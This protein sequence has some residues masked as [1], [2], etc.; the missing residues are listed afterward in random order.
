[1]TSWLDEITIEQLENDPYPIFARLRREAPIAWI[2]VL[3]S[4][5]ASNWEYCWQIAS[6]SQN[7]TG[8]TD[9]ALE[10]VFG[11]PCILSVDGEVHDDLRAMIDP[12]LRPRAV[13]RYIDGL[14]RPIARKYLAEIMDRGSAALMAEYFEP[15]SVRAVGDMLGLKQV[16]S[17]TL[18][19]WF[20]DLSS[21][22]VN[23]AVD[24]QGNFLN[25][26]GFTA[27]DAAHAEIKA[28][29]N[30]LLDRLEKEP[31]DSALSH[32]LHDGMP[33]GQVRPREHIYPTLL[34]ILLGGMQ[35][36]GHAAGATLLG[37]FTQ[38]DQLRRVIDDKR[39]IQKAVQEGLRW[40]SPITTTMGRRP[41]QNFELGGVTLP[42]GQNVL[43]SYGSANRDEAQFEQ[44]EIY[45]LDRPPQPHLAFGTGIHV[46]AGVAFG[47][48]VAQI[49]L[50]ELLGALSSIEL[51]AD[52]E[53]VVWGWFFRGPRELHVR[54]ST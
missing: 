18:R 33:E 47:P 54:W 43:L 39:L 5:M 46:C 45:N 24:A 35:E 11:Q 36:P 27:S 4:W 29:V 28:V 19:R 25:P 26:A 2:P 7:F 40:L 6:D 12:N 50:E 32:W 30:P 10:H 20:H 41:K 48:Q 52:Q 23:K 16:D 13:N 14:A 53:V 1:M 22:F 34:V 31:D 51:D 38:P 42:V 9:P 21:G 44:P 49:A 37:L 8:G 15:V 17:N 3:G